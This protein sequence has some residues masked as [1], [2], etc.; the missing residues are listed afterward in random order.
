MTM[1]EQCRKLDNFKI[2][3]TLNK[4]RLHTVVR[5]LFIDK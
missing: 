5:K 1:L 2:K 4:F 3:K